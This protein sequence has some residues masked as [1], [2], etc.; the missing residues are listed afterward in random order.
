M[1]KELKFQ[2]FQAAKGACAA[3]LTYPI[4]QN[5][6]WKDSKKELKTKENPAQEKKHTCVLSKCHT[7]K[8]RGGPEP[9]GL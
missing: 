1:G 5:W 7:S 4:K 8:E 3:L 6:G 9:G 2:E